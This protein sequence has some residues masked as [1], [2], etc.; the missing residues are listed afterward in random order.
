MQIPKALLL[1]VIATLL[2]IGCARS[3]KSVSFKFVPPA[4]GPAGPVDSSKYEITRGETV[5]VDAKPIEPLATAAYPA[6]Y[7]KPKT[8]AV[9][10]IVNIVVGADGRVEDIARSMAD[11]SE[12][13]PFS[14]ECFEA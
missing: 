4:S 7:P 13:T 3:G 2:S 10:I 14:R 6:D 9:T 1:L 12:P 11:L 8:A 5:F